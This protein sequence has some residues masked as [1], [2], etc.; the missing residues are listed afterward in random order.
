MYV[1]CYNTEFIVVT[2]ITNLKTYMISMFVTCYKH[3]I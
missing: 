3:I 2:V 1:T